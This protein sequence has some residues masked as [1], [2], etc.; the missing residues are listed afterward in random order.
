MSIYLSILMAVLVIGTFSF[1]WERRW[2]GRRA[3]AEQ[4]HNATDTSQVP[5]R[6]RLQQSIATLRANLPLRRQ[7]SELETQFRAWSARALVKDE[8]VRDWL[9]T[10]SSP[11][12]VAFVEHVAEFA[13]EMGFNLADL[14]SGKMACVPTVT[15]YAN[16]IVAHYCRANYQAAL[17]QE[18]FDGYRLYAAYL[19]TP[20]SVDSRHFAQQLYAQLVDQQLVTAPTAELLALTEQER[21]AQMQDT[22]R[23]AAED[24]DTF[25]LALVAV[26]AERQ[27]TAADFTVASI[28]QRAMTKIPK[29]QTTPPSASPSPAQDPPIA[30]AETGEEP[31]VIPA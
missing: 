20:T 21:L 19:Q 16:E 3:V 10:L 23:Q 13:E 1:V 25:R 31:T 9:N 24:S 14:V 22:I 12:H 17:A 18:E 6:A 7:S 2:K 11:A 4:D 15:V 8:A 5:V 28:V 29:T 27:R 30:T 26:A